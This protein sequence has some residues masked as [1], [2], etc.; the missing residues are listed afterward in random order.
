MFDT[1]TE[2]L[3]TSLRNIAGTG[4]LTEDNIKDTLREVRMA[5]L[6][7][8]VALPVAR[9]FVAKVKQEALGQQVLK[10]LAPGQAFVKIVYDELSEMMGSANQ[11]LEMTAKPPMVYLLAGLQGAGKTTTAGKL[12]KFLQ[13]K[14]NKKVM[15][16]SADIYRPAAIKQLEQVAVQVGASFVP[17]QSDENPLDIARRAI[18]QAR[19]QY[20]D[21]LIIDTAGRLHIDDEMMAEIKALTAAVEP[22]ETLFVV[23]SM[24]GQDAANTAKAFND[25][26]P[27]TGVIL[28]KTDG[29]ARGG[30]A[31]SVRAI[32]G[33]PIKFLGRGEKL[34]A[35][36]LF[37]PERIAQ[38]ILGMGDVLSLV[39][40]V[41]QKIDREQAEKMAKKIQKG[42]EFDLED[43]LNQFQQMKNLGGMAGFLDKM[44]GLGGADIQKAMQEAK[45][46]EKVKEME[47]LIHSMTPFE[48]QNPDK[49]TPSRK[50]RIAAGSGKQ[51]Q[52]VNRLLKQHK[53]MAKMMK[54][55]SRPD[56]ISKMMKAVQGLAKGMS[57]GPLFGNKDATATDMAQMQ[58]SMQQMGL[59]PNNLPSMEEMQQK[60]Q[61]LQ[62]QMPPNFKKRF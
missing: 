21:I 36:E 28:T 52:D 6:E 8:D 53:Q 1:L 43:L 32:T 12:A 16:V 47:A 15:L 55:I 59:D 41:E 42:G 3:S 51:I 45:P 10:E 2:R 44:P 4:Q 11:S 56:G 5:L 9:D 48:R 26:L 24:T 46:E 62:G 61:Q 37:H 34:D 39:E 49:I 35:L 23:D 50:R 38:R 58:Q 7:A 25:A 31:L 54:M 14:H 18:E 17:S 40:E 57:G 60:M 22:V 27:L 13:D 30:A 19:L 29:D 20:Q 33:K